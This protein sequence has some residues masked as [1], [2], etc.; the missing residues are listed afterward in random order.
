MKHLL[1]LVFVGLGTTLFAQNVLE[2][3]KAIRSVIQQQ[4]AAWNRDDWEA[5]SSH[6]ADDGTLINFVGQF[7]KGR[8]DINS[9]F[10]VLAA[11]CLNPTSLKFRVT[12]LRFITPAIAIVYL[13]ETLI[14]D[15]DYNVPFHNYK[16]GETDY[17]LV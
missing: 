11:C 2:D 6:F 14:A 8:K 1:L 13:E 5:F 17:K 16:K 12:G 3:E 10:K 4:E 9:H 7:W 15:Y